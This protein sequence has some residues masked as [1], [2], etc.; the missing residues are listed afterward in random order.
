M[1][2]LGVEGNDLGFGNRTIGVGS[3][4]VAV[5]LL[6]NKMHVP[7]LWVQRGYYLVCV[8]IHAL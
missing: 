6:N 1:E 2:D 4:V 5:D 8:C 7:V 3:I